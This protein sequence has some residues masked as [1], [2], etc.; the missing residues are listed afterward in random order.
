MPSLLALV[1]EAMQKHASAPEVQ[2]RGSSCISLL[3]P[4]V[5]YASLNAMA[6]TAIAA[7]AWQKH[8]NLMSESEVLNGSRRF[9]RRVDVMAGSAAALRAFCE[10]CRRLPPGHG[11]EVIVESLRH[12]GA[13]DCVEQVFCFFSHYEDSTEMLEDAAAV[14]AQLSGVQALLSRLSDEPATSLLR[15][16]GLKA[17]FEEARIDPDFFTSLAASSAIEACESMVQEAAEYNESGKEASDPP[18]DTTRLHEVASL[19]S[20]LCRGRL[21]GM[22]AT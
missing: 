6:P 3:V 15:V 9:P 21:H 22:C 7:V 19:V 8:L 4:Y 14:H 16:A 2:G 11:S 10:L 18:I 1:I 13:V 12:H 17:L 20:G 5:P